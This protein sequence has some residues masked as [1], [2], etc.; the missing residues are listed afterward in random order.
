MTSNYRIGELAQKANVTKRTIHYYISKGLLPPPTGSGVGSYYGDEHL[1]RILLIKKLKDKYL[2][3]EK[4]KEIIAHL[5][6]EEIEEK[7]YAY[8]IMEDETKH[9]EI[10]PTE[11][12]SDFMLMPEHKP[13]PEKDSTEYIKVFLG[14]GIELH[15]PKKLERERPH[16][17]KSIITY[18]KKMIKEE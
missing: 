18:T 17:I 9:L 6:P 8:Y 10:E 16:L 12:D 11:L 13:E 4:I 2:P 3:L 7:L 15:Y 5:S 14:S 1:Y